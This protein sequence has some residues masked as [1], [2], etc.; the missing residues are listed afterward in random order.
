ME[1]GKNVEHKSFEEKLRELE[2]FSLEKRRFRGD[3]IGLYNSL[4]GGCSH[5]AVSLFSQLRS[6]RTRGSVLKFC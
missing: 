2:V 6:G 1:L 3:L 4:K 5:L